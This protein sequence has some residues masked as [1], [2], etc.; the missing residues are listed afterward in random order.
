MFIVTEAAAVQVRRA[1]EQSGAEGM[2]LRLAAQKKAN[3][4]IDYL[5]G[6]DEVKED[7]I[8]FRSQGVDIVMAPE[9][10]PLLDETV[11]DFVEL[12]E[13]GHQFVFLNPKDPEYVPP[14]EN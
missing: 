13:G 10:V 14:Q 4:S 7:D 6:F 11:M 12:D 9:H 1:A 5:M 8:R 2:A 3:G